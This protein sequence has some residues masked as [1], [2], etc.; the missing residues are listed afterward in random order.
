M[1]YLTTPEYVRN[2]C[3]ELVRINSEWFSELQDN[4]YYFPLYLIVILVPNITETINPGDIDLIVWK[5]GQ[6]NLQSDEKIE[7]KP[8]FQVRWFFFSQI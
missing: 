6:A 8:P 7:S 2:I 3:L 1:V 5:F 4:L